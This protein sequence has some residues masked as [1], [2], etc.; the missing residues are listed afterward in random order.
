MAAEDLVYM[1]VKEGKRPLPYNDGTGPKE[2]VA[3]EIFQGPPRFL[4]E[5]RDHIEA[6]DETGNVIQPAPSLASAE[7]DVTFQQA[8][9]HEQVTMLEQFKAKRIE[10]H[11]REIADLDAQI[12]RK[13]GEA[14]KDAQERHKRS[15]DRSHAH[16]GA[17]QP[18]D[19]REARAVMPKKGKPHDVDLSNG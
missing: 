10:A 6:V 2:H 11:Q 3:G 16:E 18:A 1:R 19:V 15:V 5:F 14:E 17:E 12:E 8:K 9:P 13:K 7:A 4:V